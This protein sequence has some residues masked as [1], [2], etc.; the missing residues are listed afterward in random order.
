V[1]APLD[2]TDASLNTSQ[3]FN[4]SLVGAGVAK[5]EMINDGPTVTHRYGSEGYWWPADKYAHYG[6]K[7]AYRDER[8]DYIYIWGGPPNH[9][10]DPIESQYSYLARVK[11]KEAFDLQSYEYFW[12]RQRGWRKEVLDDFTAETAVTWGVG[13]GQVLFNKHLGCYM[14]VSVWIGELILR[15][16]PDS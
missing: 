6:D 11:A 3:N 10:D 15:S 7:A 12:G 16:G 9:V 5:L 4:T 2:S 8:S 13:Q 14:F 1:T